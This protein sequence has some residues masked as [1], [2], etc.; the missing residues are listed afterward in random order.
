MKR[1]VSSWR[2][3]LALTLSL[4]P[5]GRLTAQQA[6][7]FTDLQALTNSDV[8]WTFA[9]P[10][11]GVWRVDVTSDLA[12][13]DT[14]SLVSFDV[15]TGAYVHADSAT[16]FAGAR[17]YRATPLTGT[18]LVTGDHL[19]TANGDAVIHPL[20]H[21]GVALRWNGE[22]VYV[23]PT[24][25]VPSLPRADVIFITHTH[26][27]HFNTNIISALRA[28]TG[29][30]V[31]PPPVYSNLSASLQSVTTVLTNGASTNVLGIGVDAIA[32]YNLAG[33]PHA[34]GS[35]NG[36]VLT[37][38]GRRIYFS[39]DTDDTPELRALQHIDV[40]FI[41]MRGGSPNMDV[42]EAVAAVRAF[43]PHIV[44]P[45]HYL[46]N[47]VST[48]RPLLGTDLGIEVRYRKWY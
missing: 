23:D 13:T 38:G 7:R 20:I 5:G 34:R 44:Y 11:G 45:Y 47:D 18:R 48:F 24:N 37:L 1:T 4:C 27:D 26:Q 15:G 25:D 40:A 3:G 43:R 10:S 21:A 39:G 35:G 36:Y 2:V 31:T 22:T 14:A 42:A 9:A 30:L 17:F 29:I 46:T 6:P 41:A 12:L 28:P 19:A 32:M 8:S 16:P 33:T